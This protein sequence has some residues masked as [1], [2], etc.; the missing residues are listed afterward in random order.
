MIVALYCGA[1]PVS[2]PGPTQNIIIWYKC[3]KT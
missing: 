2:G 1:V 3:K